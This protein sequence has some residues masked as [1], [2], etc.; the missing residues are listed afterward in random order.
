[1]P[2]SK[3]SAI[4][5]RF[6]ALLLCYQKFYTITY[7]QQRIQ[8]RY[9]LY[10]SHQPSSNLGRGLRVGARVTAHN[11]HLCKKGKVGGFTNSVP[12][13]KHAK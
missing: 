3:S 1:M 7:F 9:R 12:V 4:L 10:I 13:H 8:F 11:V 6:F 2:C 5:F